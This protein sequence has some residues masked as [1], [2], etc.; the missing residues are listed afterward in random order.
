VGGGVGT[1]VD[2]FGADGF[3][4]GR[5]VGF[6]DGVSTGAFVGSVGRRVGFGDGVPTG[7]FVGNEPPPLLIGDFVGS[8]EVGAEEGGIGAF[9]G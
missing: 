3:A 6:G 1:G 2:G 8:E 9:D 7:A 4:V 5:R